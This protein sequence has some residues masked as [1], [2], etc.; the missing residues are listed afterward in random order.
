MT[1]RQFR[2]FGIPKGQPR[3]R[4]F[5]RKMGNR[6]VARVFDPGTADAWKADVV[7][8]ARE[9]RPDEPLEGPVRVAIDFYLR[10]PKRLMRKR[11]PDG[12]IWCT[13]KP[14]RDN[15]DKAVLDALTA[16]GWFRDDCQVVAGEVRKFY[17]GKAEAPGA[18]ITVEPI[19]EE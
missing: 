7:L 11:D 17:H 18:M 16:D 15:L 12:T 9:H 4:T 19:E 6:H 3:P 8:S 5:A 10:R 14:D 13:S 1:L 2:V